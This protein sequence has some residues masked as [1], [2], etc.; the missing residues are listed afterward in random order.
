MVHE[1]VANH[2]RFCS[3]LEWGNTWDTPGHVVPNVHYDVGSMPFGMERDSVYTGG[4]T[5]SRRSR[6]I[7]PRLEHG[8]IVCCR[9]TG[10]SIMFFSRFDRGGG[11]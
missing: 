6:S 5:V 1:Y 10:L 3:T 11:I 4:Y 8:N 7:I 9:I 2:I